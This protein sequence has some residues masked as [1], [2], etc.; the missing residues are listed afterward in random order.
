MLPLPILH[1]HYYGRESDSETPLL[2]DQL[3][4]TPLVAFAPFKLRNDYS[5]ACKR[6]LRHSDDAE[7]DVGFDGIEMDT[8]S[9]LSHCTGT[10]GSEKFY[11]DQMGGSD[12]LLQN[13]K[14]R[15]PVI[16][17]GGSLAGLDDDGRP[18]TS[19]DGSNHFLQCNALATAISGSDQPFSLFMKMYGTSVAGS[20]DPIAFTASAVSTRRHY[21]RLV[22]S[23]GRYSVTRIDDAG[24]S[25]AAVSDGNPFTVNTWMT[26]SYIFTGTTTSFWVNGVLQ[27]NNGP[28]DVGT[29]TYDTFCLG[30]RDAAGTPSSHFPGR[31]T[32]F[33][34][35]DS[36]ASD[37][38]RLLIE[39]AL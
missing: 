36:V 16:V 4:A 20:Y 1:R 38:D 5:G 15:Q 32:S 3:S 19:Y 10:T 31:I 8:A 33:L 2:L 14:T 9:L 21:L 26:F 11:Y 35:F 37:D 17:S 25:A 13:T 28:M 27:E 39:A 29:A 23:T 7:L 18:F 12:H 24:A 6:V 30:A 34:L 22:G